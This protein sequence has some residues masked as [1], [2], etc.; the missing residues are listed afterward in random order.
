MGHEGGTPIGKAFCPQ[1][2][3]SIKAH[4]GP[5]SPSGIF[6]QRRL[7]VIALHQET[8]LD[9]TCGRSYRA[10]LERSTSEAVV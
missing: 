3:W 10:D 9:E 7:L 2:H 6:F 8:K 4:L 5:A 1:V